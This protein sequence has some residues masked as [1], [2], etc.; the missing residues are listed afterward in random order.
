MNFSFTGEFAPVRENQT[1]YT[2]L[3]EICYWRDW[4]NE[5]DQDTHVIAI[6]YGAEMARSN[7]GHEPVNVFARVHHDDIEKLM[8]IGERVWLKGTEKV[9]FQQEHT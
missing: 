6:Y 3:G 9:Y 5:R 1:I 7:R 2:S 4:D 8:E